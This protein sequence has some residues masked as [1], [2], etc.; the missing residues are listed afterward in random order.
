M[1][2]F[3]LA[4]LDV[5]I[6]LVTVYLVFALACTAIVEAISAWTSVRSKNLEAALKEFLAGNWEW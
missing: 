1:R 4:A 3:G 6:G 2:V 5:L